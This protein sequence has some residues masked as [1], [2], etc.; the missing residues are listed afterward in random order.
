[1]KK[2]IKTVA[3]AVTM[4]VLLASCGSTSKAE[5]NSSKKAKKTKFNQTEFDSAY[6]A[7]DFGTCLNMIESRGSDS[8]L[9]G[10]DSS[11][12]LYLSKDYSGSGRSFTEIQGEMNSVSKDMTA[13][14]TMEAALISENSVTYSGATYERILAYSM[15]AVDSFKLG[16]VSSAVGV[17]NDYTGNY[18]EEIA[19]LVAQ[20]KELAKSSEGL[21]NDP[22]VSQAT[23]A[24]SKAGIPVNFSSL[25][26]KAPASTSA[27]YEASPFLSYLGTLAYAANGD[28]V[29]AKD[30]ASVLKSTNSSVDV[31]EDLTVPAGKGRLDVIA[32]TDKIGQRTQAGEQELI[33][34]LGNVLVNFKVVYPIFGKQNH[35]ISVSKVTLSNGESKAFTLIEDFDEAVK[36]DVES[37]AHGAYNRSLFRNI[38]KNSAA[39]VAGIASLKAAEEAVNKAKG[40]KL[41]EAAA[42]K[43]YE[44]AV[45]SVNAALIAVVDA[46]KADV[47]QASYFPHKASAAGFTVEPGTYTVTVEYSDGT[48]D[49]KDVTVA[50]GKPTVVI[51]EKMN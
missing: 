42:T 45:T 22:K 12:L 27:V 35:A 26:S 29:H 6:K 4:A 41:K 15:K 43:A 46:E 8:I 2:I 9:T 39:V 24:M 48:K 28:T 31:S 51:S 16:N 3:F 5:G 30:F 49:V 37:K 25:I 36:T 32:L 17:M 38:T 34:Q 47:R 18:K 50:A 40:N 19:A 23:E 33:G 7:G 1:M 21:T 20:Q 13:A 14:K 10:L 44:A 11:M